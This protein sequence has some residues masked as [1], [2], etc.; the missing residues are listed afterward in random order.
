VFIPE[1]A[2]LVILGILHKI[3]ENYCLV[4]Q[5]IDLFLC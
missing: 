5:S 3:R 1:E 4:S 2:N